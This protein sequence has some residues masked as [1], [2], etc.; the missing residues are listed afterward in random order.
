MQATC[1]TDPN[2]N[3]E[4]QKTISALAYRHRRYG[5]GMI[6]LKV[7]QQ[8]RWMN[9]K[10]VERLYA[11]IQLHVRGAQAIRCRWARVTR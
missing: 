11:D 4:L 6:Y 5:A 7:R 8:S 3:A 2:R 9:S 1:R 10:Q